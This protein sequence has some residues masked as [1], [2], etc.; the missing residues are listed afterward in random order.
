MSKNLQQFG[1]LLNKLRVQKELTLREVCKLANYDPSNWSK[2]E[3]GKL[4]PPSNQKVLRKW[5]G[6]LGLK[7]ASK[8]FQSF[9]DQAQICQGII[10][11]DV[12]SEQE[13]VGM[14]PAFFRTMRGE[15]PTKQEVDKLIELMRKNH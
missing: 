2:I 6:V 10:P 4:S 15:K 8:D 9:I 11:S 3:R 13:L 14:L 12:L 1:K 7:K 5:A